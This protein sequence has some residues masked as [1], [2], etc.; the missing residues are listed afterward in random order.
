MKKC[1]F[2]AEEIQE[3]AI[4]CRYCGEMLT[5]AGADSPETGEI[6][7]AP[8]YGWYLSRL[9]PGGERERTPVTTIR[10]LLRLHQ[11]GE[12]RSGDLVSG[13]VPHDHSY[14]A[15]HF[16][17]FHVCRSCGYIGYQGVQNPIN[18]WVLL[19]LFL[20]FFI[21]GLIYLAWGMSVRGKVYCLKCSAA[22]TTVPITAESAQALLGRAIEELDL[23]LRPYEENDA[24][25]TS[26]EPTPVWKALLFILLLIGGVLLLSLILRIVS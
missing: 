5:E 9:M 10:E 8:W 15:Q 16:L 20:F 2:C 19:L 12:L 1:P 3:A 14:P 22:N 25:L 21:P 4:K 17:S 11:M 24:G 23:P 18:G 13:P 26:R 7:R 6:E